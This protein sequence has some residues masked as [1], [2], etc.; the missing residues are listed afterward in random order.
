MEQMGEHGRG[1]ARGHIS[2]QESVQLGRA[3]VIVAISFSHR[4]L[5]QKKQ[6]S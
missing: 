5:P 2:E 6:M 1:L 3:G 4:T